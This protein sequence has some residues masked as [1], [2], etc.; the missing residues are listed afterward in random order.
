MS[1]YEPMVVNFDNRAMDQLLNSPSGDVG[2]HMRRIG[3][4]ILDGAKRLVGVRTGALKRSLYMRHERS[5]RGQLITVGSNLRHALVHHEGATPHVIIAH[6]RVLRFNQG[7]RI[8]YTR[9]VSH[10][11]FRGRNYLTVPL[12]SAV[13]G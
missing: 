7:G 10:P 1:M 9:R 4:L 12:R 3:K 2:R 8:I 6:G 13:R 5:A 11:G